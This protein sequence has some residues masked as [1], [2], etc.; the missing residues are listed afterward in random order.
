[1]NYKIEL[2]KRSFK[3]LDKLDRNTK[4]RISQQ[5]EI[6]SENPRASDM[7]LRIHF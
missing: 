6:L 5:L 1:M 2:S 3:Y 4:R 7:P